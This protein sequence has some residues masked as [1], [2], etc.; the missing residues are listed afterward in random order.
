[1][2]GSATVTIAAQAQAN[3]CR[4]EPAAVEEVP[5]RMGDGMKVTRTT[6]RGEAGAAEIV[7]ITV[8]GARVAGP[9]GIGGARP[10]DAERVG[11]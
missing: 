11:Q 3:G 9:T 4:E 1:M 2:R 6:Y 7:L 8:A 10:L 5:D